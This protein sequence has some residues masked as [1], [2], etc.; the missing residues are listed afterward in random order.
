MIIW[1]SDIKEVSYHAPRKRFKTDIDVMF[2]DSFLTNIFQYVAYCEYLFYWFYL[3]SQSITVKI[4]Y[5]TL[6]ILIPR[7]WRWWKD[8]PIDGHAFVRPLLHKPFH[9]FHAIFEKLSRKSLYEHYNGKVYM[10]Q[11][12]RLKVRIW[13]GWEID[14]CVIKT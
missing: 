7:K 1:N 2:I 14:L 12:Q 8:L 6:K 9:F 4:A 10:Y 13:F 3:T 11:R 5:A